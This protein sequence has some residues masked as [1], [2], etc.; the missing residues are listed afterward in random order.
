MYAIDLYVNGQKFTLYPPETA[1]KVKGYGERTRPVPSTR[2]EYHYETGYEW[3]K[4]ILLATGHDPDKI[5]PAV[6]QL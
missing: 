1:R 4:K 2:M 6:P 3:W 5:D